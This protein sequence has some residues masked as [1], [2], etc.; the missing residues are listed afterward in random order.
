[1][2][3]DKIGFFK[4]LELSLDNTPEGFSMRK[5][6]AVAGLVVAISATFRF[7]DDRV[8]IWALGIWLTFV[9]MCL[10]IVTAEQIL[11]FYKKSDNDVAKSPTEVP[12]TPVVED[13]KD[14]NVIVKQ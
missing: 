5:L 3:I 13:V 11:K 1:M 4:K 12:P 7:V 9:L 2:G 10:G 8:I 6:Q 14:V